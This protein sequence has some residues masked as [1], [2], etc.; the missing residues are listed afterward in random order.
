MSIRLGDKD[1]ANIGYPNLDR[2]LVI[3]IEAS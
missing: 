2:D 1:E 3:K